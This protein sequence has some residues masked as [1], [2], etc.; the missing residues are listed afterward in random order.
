MTRKSLVSTACFNSAMVRLAVQWRANTFPRVRASCLLSML[1]ATNVKQWCSTNARLTLMRCLKYSLLDGFFP[2]LGLVMSPLP[3]GKRSGKHFVKKPIW[4][5][6]A[7][8]WSRLGQSTSKCFLMLSM[9]VSAPAGRE[10]M[11]ASSVTDSGLAAVTSSS[12]IFM[13]AG[14]M[15]GRSSKMSSTG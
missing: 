3:S 14:S 2:I 12:G 13:A 7:G 6:D 10:S 8:W 1:V 11:D 15:Q 9:T 5:S 4:N